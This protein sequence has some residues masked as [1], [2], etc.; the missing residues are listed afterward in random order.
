MQGS[1]RDKKS[2]SLT[3]GDEEGHEGCWYFFTQIESFR[4]RTDLPL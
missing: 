3:L 1:H 2:I 4:K